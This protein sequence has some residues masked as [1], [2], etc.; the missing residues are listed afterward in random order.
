MVEYIEYKGKKY[1]VRVSYYALKMTRKESGKNEG[2]FNKSMQEALKH[3]EKFDIEIYETMLWFALLAGAEFEDTKLTIPREKM[4]FVLDGCFTEFM[5]I[6][7]KFQPKGSELVG[8]EKKEE[9]KGNRQQRR[10]GK[11]IVE[12]EQL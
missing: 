1:A 2:N 3:P 6:I 12:K 4:E 11:T 5:A 7:E 8:D 9:P 10:T